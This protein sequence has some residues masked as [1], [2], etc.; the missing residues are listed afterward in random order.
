MVDSTEAVLGQIQETRAYRRTVVAVRCFGLGWL[1]FM[2]CFAVTFAGFHPA[3]LVIPVAWLLAVIGWGMGI[4]AQ[5]QL[6]RDFGLR[7]RT[8]LSSSLWRAVLR[9]ALPGRGSSQ[10]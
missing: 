5:R 6:R 3:V 4:T 2:V 9:D 1:G 10:V 7:P 8:A